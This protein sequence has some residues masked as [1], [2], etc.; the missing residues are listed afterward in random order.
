MKNKKA[1]V[2]GETKGLDKTFEQSNLKPSRC[3]ASIHGR[4]EGEI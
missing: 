2:F 4:K 1:F 3:F